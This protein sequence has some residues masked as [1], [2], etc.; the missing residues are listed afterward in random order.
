MHADVI[1]CQWREISLCCGATSNECSPS[2]TFLFTDKYSDIDGLVHE[3]H[4]SI[5]NVKCVS[6]V[7][8]DGD[9]HP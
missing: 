9:A 3:R 7:D 8:G 6:A 2:Y 4:D 1:V 5:A